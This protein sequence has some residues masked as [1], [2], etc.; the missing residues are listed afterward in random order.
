MLCTYLYFTLTKDK[1]F[2]R[3]RTKNRYRYIFSFS[4]RSHI[5]DLKTGYE[6][7]KHS[8]YQPPD[9]CFKIQVPPKQGFPRWGGYGGGTPPPSENWPN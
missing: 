3:M 7:Y 1:S 5:I 2:I 4:A 6:K 8:L 9:Y